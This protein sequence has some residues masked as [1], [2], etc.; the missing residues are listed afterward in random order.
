M[1]GNRAHTWRALSN[2]NLDGRMITNHVRDFVIVLTSNDSRTEW[3]PIRSLIVRVTT[4]SA[5]VLFVFH[6]YDCRPNWTTR[7]LITNNYKKLQF[8]RKED[9]LSYERKGKFAFKKW[10]SRSLH[11]F[12]DD[13][14]QGFDCL[15]STTTLNVIGWFKLQLW[16]WLAYRI[17]Q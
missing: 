5:G 7:S 2:S 17:V 13:L 3:S 11:C 6:K 12:Y 4:K 8:P 1:R 9:R 15:I 16:M 14:N 10:Q